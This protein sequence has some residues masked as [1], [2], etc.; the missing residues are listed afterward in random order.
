MRHAGESLAQALQ[1]IE[2]RRVV[3]RCQRRDRL[4]QG[5]IGVVDQNGVVQIGTAVHDA[6][7]ECRD[8]A[9]KRAIGQ[10]GQGLHRRMRIGG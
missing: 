3:Q 5:Q 7:A 8:I 1:H 2:R 4:D 9:G 10:G 6:V